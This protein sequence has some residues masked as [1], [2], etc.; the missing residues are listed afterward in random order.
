MHGVPWGYKTIAYLRMEGNDKILMHKSILSISTQLCSCDKYRIQL[1]GHT[2]WYA[3]KDN[4]AH[5]SI[6]NLDD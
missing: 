1:M 3:F 5:E 2:S 6:G 4:V